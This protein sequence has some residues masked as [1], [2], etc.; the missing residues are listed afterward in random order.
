MPARRPKPAR[1]KTTARPKPLPADWALLVPLIAESL[2]LMKRDQFV[3]FACTG[4][5]RFVQFAVGGPGRI[6]GEVVS[7]HFL[8]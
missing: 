1:K 5:N 6:R 7:D 3:I 8:D 2:R 4:H